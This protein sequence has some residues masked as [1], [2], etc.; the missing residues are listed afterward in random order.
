[1]FIDVIDCQTHE[2][3]VKWVDQKYKR[4]IEAII[5]QVI[6]QESIVTSEQQPSHMIFF[7]KDESNYY[8]HFLVNLSKNFVD[9]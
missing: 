5:V 4:V 2:I 1:M 8:Q 6:E 9:P 7:G 3:F